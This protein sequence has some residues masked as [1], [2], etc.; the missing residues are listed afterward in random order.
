[1]DVSPAINVQMGSIFHHVMGL[2]MLGACVKSVE[3]VQTGSSSKNNATARLSVHPT[4]IV[5]LVHRVT[6]P[7]PR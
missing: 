6:P 1:V 7:T 2:E 3:H 5:L 4:G